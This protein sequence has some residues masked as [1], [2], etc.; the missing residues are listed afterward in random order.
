MLVFP[1]I[2]N[3]GATREILRDLSLHNIMMGLVLL[4]V[5]HVRT[6]VVPTRTVPIPSE[7]SFMLLVITGKRGAGELVG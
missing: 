4:V 7:E 3:T 1:S 5:V 6:T 2:A